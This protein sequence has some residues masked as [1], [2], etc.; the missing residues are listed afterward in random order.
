MV[1]SFHLID[2]RI[3]SYSFRGNY[4]FLNWE[5]HGSQYIRSKVTVHKCAEIIQVRKLFKGKNYMRKY[6]KSN[7]K[8]N[9]SKLFNNPFY[10]KITYLLNLSSAIRRSASY[11]FNIILLSFTITPV[12]LNIFFQIK[13]ITVK[14]RG[15]VA[16]FCLFTF[17]KSS[18]VPDI[19]FAAGA[20][21]Y[22]LKRVNTVQ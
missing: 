20:S 19:N 3:S 2:Y 12:M 9:S 6:G 17:F 15:E 11:K 10:I 5:I 18:W 13:C 8:N 16:Y 14:S 22:F 1:C 4:S 21:Q 7:M